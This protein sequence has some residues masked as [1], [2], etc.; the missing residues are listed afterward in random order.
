MTTPGITESDRAGLGP[1]LNGVGAVV[2]AFS[3][4][5][6]HLREHHS[7]LVLVVS[8]VALLAWVVR[9]FSSNVVVRD[10]SAVLMLV[11]G[12]AM[13][14]PTNALL[15]TPAIVATAGV[16]SDM[17]K[18]LRYG[19][20]FTTV[21]AAISVA[22]VVVVGGD[23]SFGLSVIAG[24]AIGF[25]LGVNRR[26]NRE[27]LLRDRELAH[28]TAEI[29]T[30]KGRSALLAD[31][32]EIARDIHDVLAHSLGGLVIQLD[33][34]SALLENGRVE[35]AAA[36]V[37]AAR[38]LAAEGLGE[39][40]RAVATLRDPDQRAA[41][42]ADSLAAPDAIDRLLAAHEALGGVA[43]VEGR[44]ALDRLDAAH[45]RVLAA[46]IREALS[47]A[48][49]HAA[50]EPV[51]LAFSVGEPGILSA[52]ISNRAPRAEPSPG[53]GHGVPGMTERL[54]ALG[55]GSSLTAGRQGDLFVVDARVVAS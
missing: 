54:V 39:A 17:R 2:V 12:A 21:G 45:R 20:V 40:R 53:G 13:A 51:S 49:R 31:R 14:G 19:L 30:E 15:I 34:T 36:R 1:A 11:G 10:V 26:Q 7:T 33:A 38:T 44:P 48:R 29:E 5:V 3:L 22:S 18:S 4:I 25:V 50:G 9:S 24:A 28:R 46:V 8:L 35:E 41:D 16:T 43:T 32:A 37:T 55:D 42:Q 47:N 6:G 23:L 52:R 27:S